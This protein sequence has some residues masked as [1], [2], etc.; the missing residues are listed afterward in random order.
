MTKKFTKEQ[1]IE[2]CN[3]INTAMARGFT[4]KAGEHVI[5]GGA[6]IHN[7]ALL[8]MPRLADGEIRL[9][10]TRIPDDGRIVVIQTTEV[11]V[12][13]IYE[14]PSFDCAASNPD[15]SNPSP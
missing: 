10:L 5:E 8:H 11:E 14:P 12:D 15:L 9:P 2:I 6:I 7:G 13:V 3:A 4:V 1:Q